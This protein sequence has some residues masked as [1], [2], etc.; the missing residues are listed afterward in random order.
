MILVRRT[1]M[2]GPSLLAAVPVVH[3]I[4]ESRSGSGIEASEVGRSARERLDGLL[5]DLFAGDPPAGCAAGTEVSC[6]LSL[7]LWM[8]RRHGYEVSLAF[9]RVAP[10]GGGRIVAVFEYRDA[11]LARFAADAA[12]RLVEHSSGGE[13]PG[14]LAALVET[15]V[16]EARNH[17]LVATTRRMVFEANRRGIPWWNMHPS[18]RSMVHMGQGIHGKRVSGSYTGETSFLATRLASSKFAVTRLMREHGLP[19]PRGE[20]ARTPRQAIAAAR[21]MGFPVV[22]KPNGMDKGIGVA[23][24]ISDGAALD[25][26]YRAARPY[27]PVLIEEQLK[28]ADNRITLLRGQVV[29]IGQNLSARLTG[30]GR[31]TVRELI[32]VENR[33][34]LRGDLDHS[35]IQKIVVDDEMTRTVREQGH[36][37]DGVPAAGELVLLRRWWRH[38][39]DHTA[40][41]VT[42][43][44]HPENLVLFERAARL[45]GL[46]IVGVDFITPDITRP[47]HE[48]GGGINEVNPTPGLNAHIRTGD[49]QIL[50][51][52]LEASFPAGTDGRIP[53]AVV[54]GPEASGVAA[55]LEDL[56]A[57]AGHTVGR[58][59]GGELRIGGRRHVA[60]RGEDLDEEGA[61]LRDPVVSAAILSP[62]SRA[63]RRR[64]LGVD[65]VPVTVVTGVTPGEEE[66]VELL[67]S[68]TRDFLVLDAGSASVR[69]RGGPARACWVT[70]DPGASPARE[71][72]ARG[73]VA[74]GPGEVLGSRH[75]CLW[76]E[77]K[78]VAFMGVP[79][80]V[81][82]ATMTALAAAWA[83]GMTPGEIGRCFEPSSAS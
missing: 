57:R 3:M 64:G 41:D 24:G 56:L 59:G 43:I 33:N 28:G 66:L 8:Q 53:L 69:E 72:I 14:G 25:R 47:W 7:A 68:V 58:A 23:V 10:G 79:A 49:T 5:P 11:E 51:Q 32:D 60:A 48:V 29:A 35:V 4:L 22:V 37:L 18:L 40:R 76:I 13:A 38:A 74:V 70:T 63:V 80:E 19:A 61:V 1:L 83:M 73:G 45:I 26:A 65:R 21:R 20:L 39:K 62:G 31:S 34:P 67:I 27:G 15:S 9:A 46:D 55:R 82:P 17:V 77:G 30:D 81:D 44:T 54:V 2:R 42:S 6:L 50:R 16:T 36:G 12:M 78:P 71:H 52:V 75:L